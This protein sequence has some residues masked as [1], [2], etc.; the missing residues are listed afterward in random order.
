LLSLTTILFREK[1]VVKTTIE[2]TF[3][4][5]LLVKPVILLFLYVEEYRLEPLNWTFPNL[6]GLIQLTGS[7]R[8][9]NSFHM[10]KFH[11]IKKCL[12]QHSIWREKPYNGIIG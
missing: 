1:L 9:N 4:G 5:R 12:F 7:S 3:P 2:T 10:V 11:T 6:V 8:L